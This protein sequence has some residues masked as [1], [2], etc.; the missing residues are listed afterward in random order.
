MEVKLKSNVKAL[1]RPKDK[2]KK[3][4]PI[5][6]QI[7][8]PKDVIGKIKKWEPKSLSPA[9]KIKTIINN[10]LEQDSV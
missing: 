9:M 4:K 2:P 5:L 7:R 10:L 1:L 3:D 6:V 8:F